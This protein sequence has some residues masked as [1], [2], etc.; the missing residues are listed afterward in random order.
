MIPLTT[1][2]DALRFPGTVMIDADRENGLRRSSV[3]L[4]FQLTVV[5]Q[6]VVGSRMGQVST[7]VLGDIRDAL[8]RLTGR[9]GD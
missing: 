5:D 1:Q 9:A 4:V 6:R 8:D 2:L 7:A 3:A